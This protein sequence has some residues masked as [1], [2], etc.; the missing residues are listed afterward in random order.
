MF[1][2]ASDVSSTTGW[3]T[4]SL[5]SCRKTKNLKEDGR[6][7]VTVVLDSQEPVI[8]NYR[9]RLLSKTGKWPPLIRFVRSITSYETW[10]TSV[11]VI[12]KGRKT[13]EHRMKQ[14]IS[15]K[16]KCVRYAA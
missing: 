3:L 10:T 4:M 2:D 12:L 1:Q 15:A 8:H 6:F 11:N 9:Y 7:V 13:R 5:V 16:I 14:R